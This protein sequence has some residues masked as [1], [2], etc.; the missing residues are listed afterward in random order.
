[1][2]R[3]LV[4]WPSFRKNLKDP[5]LP[6]LQSAIMIIIILIIKT[7][8]KYIDTINKVKL[9]YRQKLKKWKIITI[10]IHILYIYICTYVYIHIYAYVCTY[11]RIHIYDTKYIDQLND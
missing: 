5:V 7:I 4:R 11:I 10:I 1:M 2:V 6:Y 3:I 9:E 8:K